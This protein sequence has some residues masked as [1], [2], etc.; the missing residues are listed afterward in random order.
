MIE[1]ALCAPIFLLFDK[2]T[3]AMQFVEVH[4][5]IKALHI[6]YALGID[7]IS[8]LFLLLT[9]LIIVLSILVSWQ[10]ITTK[11]QEFFISL[12]LLE[13]AMMGVFCAT[14]FSFY[15]FWEAMLIPM[16]LIIGVWGGPA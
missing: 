12:L 7:G 6:N 13:G 8:V 3:F 10:S 5:W 14:D 1:F 4:P 11:V 2:T 9:A 15:I 16:F